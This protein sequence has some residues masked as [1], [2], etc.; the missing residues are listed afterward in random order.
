MRIDSIFRD[1]SFL[2]DFILSRKA[3]SKY[4]KLRAAALAAVINNIDNPD[5]EIPHIDVEFQK[6]LNEVNKCSST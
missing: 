1:D 5:Y 2:G 6:Q 4:K 3:K